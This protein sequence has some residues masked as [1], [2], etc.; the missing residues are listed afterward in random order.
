VGYDLHISRAVD[1]PYSRYYPILEQEVIDLTE[2]QPDL[3][4]ETPTASWITWLG[5]PDTTAEDDGWLQFTNGEIKRKWPSEDMVRRMAEIARGL[6]A[7]LTG[8]EGELHL[9][10]TD[11]KITSRHRTAEERQPDAGVYCHQYLVRDPLADDE[12]FQV[13]AQQPD[14]RIT[15]YVEA[16]LPSGWKTIPVPA[17]RAV[18]RPSLGQTRT[19]LPEH[20]GPHRSPPRRPAHGEPDDGVGAAPRRPGT[21]RR[22]TGARATVTGP[23]RRP[24]RA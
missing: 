16:L 13:A 23:S 6:D 11:G 8:D 3:R 12:W 5:A 9:V 2:A 24:P 15:P 4:R 10:D 14:F 1:W 21:S 22:L 19:V 17:G 20:A 18:D 7:W